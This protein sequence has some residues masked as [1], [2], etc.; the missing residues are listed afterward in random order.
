MRAGYFPVSTKVRN[1]KVDSKYGTLDIEDGKD[2]CEIIGISFG[3]LGWDLFVT[4]RTDEQNL[5]LN[6]SGW[7]RLELATCLVASEQRT[8]E[9][10]SRGL[11]LCLVRVGKKGRTID[12]PNR[13]LPPI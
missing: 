9:P 4:N 11:H 1:S 13:D 3:E 8:D 6:R 5:D 10:S 2:G 12:E 7:S